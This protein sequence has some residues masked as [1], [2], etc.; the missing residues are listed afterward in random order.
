MNEFYSE[1]SG[2]DDEEHCPVKVNLKWFNA[3][4]GFGFVLPESGSG[5]AFLHISVLQKAGIEEMPGEGAEFVCEI[6]D[7]PKGLQVSSIVE[8]LS[9]G[10]AIPA[11]ALV[12]SPAEEEDPSIVT[13]HGTVKWFRDDKGFGFII[14]DDGAK[15]VFI[16]QSCVERLNVEKLIPGQKVKMRFRNVDKGREVLFLEL[17]E[18]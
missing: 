12:D 9:K 7:G 18:E 4:K 5:D 16:H 2:Q 15:D 1:Q 10:T 17:V 11:G 13:M 8:V 14:P 6:D 3:D